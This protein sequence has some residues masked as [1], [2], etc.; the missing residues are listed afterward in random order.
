MIA[1]LTIIVLAFLSCDLEGTKDRND[2]GLVVPEDAIKVTVN[3][4]ARRQA[5][6]G[7]GATTRTLV[8]ETGDN[9]SSSQRQR[10]I[11]AVYGQAGLNMGHLGIGVAET[12]ADASDLWQE[13]SNDNGDP[14]VIEASGF[15]WFGSNAARQKVVS[16]AQPFGFDNYSLASKINLSVLNF[17]VPIRDSNYD[18]YLDECAEHV[19]AVLEH[20]REAYDI[21]PRTVSLFNEPTSGNTEL[22]GGSA[23][24]IADII[25]RTGRRLREAGFSEVKF[26]VPNEETVR[27]TLEVAK[28]I[29]ED[30][31]ARKYVAAVG[32]HP[33]PYGSPYS[34]PHR[35]LGASG[36]G[37]P[38]DG[39][40]ERRREL[41]EFV[42]GYDIPLWMTEVSEG[43]GNADYEF[44]SFENVRARAIHI[45]DEL[46]YGRASAYFGMNAMWDSETHREHFSGRGVPFLT[47]VSSIVLID[48]ETDEIR[49][50]GM[51]YA[52]GHYARWINRGAVRIDATSAD[53]L[54][55]V[56]AFRDGA[57]DR[58][59][60]VAINNRSDDVSLDVQ[61][62]NLRVQGEVTG[63]QSTEEQRWE[64]ISAFQPVSRQRIAFSVPGRSVTTI[65]APLDTSK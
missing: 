13:R 65:A 27:R 39:A 48:K 38:N 30:P 64:T 12:P 35:I 42:R 26:V 40:V 50:T 51:G 58:F 4:G 53:S 10:A 33:Y 3:G 18:R 36:T 29:L 8:F 52:I 45:H 23:E 44:G 15:N 6:D 60:L 41:R 28:V 24:E 46:V 47:E 11:E 37:A 9:L 20:W 1:P 43:P 56:T 31:E 34:S 21:V 32:Y 57:Q 17:L 25:K 63:E 62:S 7:F 22:K 49:I 16:L 55:Q 54:L 14:F 19:L 61:L 5:I 2:D 59:V